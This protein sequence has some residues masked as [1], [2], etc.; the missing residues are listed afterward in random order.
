MNQEMIAQKVE[1]VSGYMKFTDL[2]FSI[3]TVANESFIMNRTVPMSN[4]IGLPG[5]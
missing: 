5:I 2:R 1:F 4:E 3:K